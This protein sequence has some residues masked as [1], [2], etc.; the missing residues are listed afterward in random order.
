MAQ[1]DIDGQIGYGCES[2]RFFGDLQPPVL[3]KRKIS[4]K[5]PIKRPIAQTGRIMTVK[6]SEWFTTTSSNKLVQT[7]LQKKS[8]SHVL[9]LHNG[10]PAPKKKDFDKKEF[11][12]TMDEDAAETSDDHM[13]ADD[14]TSDDE[15][16]DSDQSDL[17]KLPVEYWLSVK[18]MQKL[19]I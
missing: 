6:R 9:L 8:P 10:T 12:E 4:P 18:K 19:R 5:N 14:E 11:D 1:F 15:D 17:P 16:E 3:K 13:D 2:D 7:E